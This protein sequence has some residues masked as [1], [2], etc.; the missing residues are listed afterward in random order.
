MERRKFIKNMAAT[1][2]GAIVMPTIVPSSVFGK[3][4]PN[5]K[6]QIGQIGCGRIARD[7]DIAETI[8]YEQ[9][10]FV[11]VCDVDSK[12][13]SEGKKYVDDFYS[14]KTGKSNYSNVKMYE[15]YREL[16]SNKDVDA[17]II[18]TPDHWHAQPAIEAA[19]AKK[20]I[21]LQKPTSLTVAEGRLLS[22]IVRRQGVIL[23]VGTQQRSSSQFRIAAE[24]VRNGRIGK[25]HTVRIGLPGDPP[26]GNPKE[27]PIPPNLNYDMWLGSTPE[28]YYTEDRVHPQ[29]GYG[30]PGW[31][32][33]EQ[34]GAGMIT[35]WGQHHIDSAAWGMD[36]EYTGPVSVQAVAEFPKWGLWDVHGDFMVKAE[37][38]NG[39]TM[40]ISNG[41]PNGIR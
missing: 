14:K 3:N 36:T 22:D 18:S 8:R 9:A 15:D 24:L 10:Q 28:V 1:T 33:C 23:Q 41:Y 25:I 30:R 7:H 2:V 34:F 40:Y 13:L 12:R 6:I 21:Y 19:L 4:A 37:Y 5:N 16:L 39:I 38:E 31:L 17:V 27:M 35:G 32:R 11:A 20:D 29:Q 26:G